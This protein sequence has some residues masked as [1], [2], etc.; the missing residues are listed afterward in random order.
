MCDRVRQDVSFIPLTWR[1]TVKFWI[2]ISPRGCVTGSVLGESY[3]SDL[4][5][6]EY[7]T[8]S[9]EERM[10]EIRRGWR[11]EL[12]DAS[13]WDMRAKPC[14]R[15]VCAH[16]TGRKAARTS[17]KTAEPSCPA[18]G[19]AITSHDDER[20]CG[21]R[22]DVCNDPDCAEPRLSRWLRREQLQLLLSRMDRGVLL[23][24]ERKLLRSAV[25]AEVNDVERAW[26]AA[27][28]A[29]GQR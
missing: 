16:R 20:P 9:R 14:L 4:E 6:H 18:C 13:E 29:T 21:E 12:V 28:K 26:A 2:R 22:W 11:H 15:G 17:H 8:P 3:A 25:M 7:F 24:E 5:A 10:E 19:H 27:A 1:N 23:P